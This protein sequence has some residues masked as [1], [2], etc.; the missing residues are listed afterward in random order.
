MCACIHVLNTEVEVG[1][2]VAIYVGHLH[3]H[4]GIKVIHRLYGEALLRREAL[5]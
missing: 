1:I 4:L 3:M 2:V 5:E